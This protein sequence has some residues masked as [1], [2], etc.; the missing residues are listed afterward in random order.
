MGSNS[1]TW[2]VAMIRRDKTD[3]CS[4]FWHVLRIGIPLALLLFLI[5][6]WVMK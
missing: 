4:D 1:K 6:P 2:A 5:L 3:P